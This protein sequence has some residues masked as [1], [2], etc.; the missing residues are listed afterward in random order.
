MPHFPQWALH[1]CH[2][3]AGL[4]LLCTQQ[5]HIPESWQHAW[6]TNGL[7]CRVACVSSIHL[8]VTLPSPVPTFTLSCP[9]WDAG[10]PGQALPCSQGQGAGLD[11]LLL[12]G[13]TVSFSTPPWPTFW[14]D[15]A[16]PEGQLVRQ[17]SVLIT[18]L[19]ACPGRVWGFPGWTTNSQWAWDEA[20]QGWGRSSFNFSNSSDTFEKWGKGWWNS[21]SRL[22][23]GAAATGWGKN[24]HTRP[25]W[26]DGSGP[27]DGDSRVFLQ[28]GA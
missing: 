24:H 5:S 8:S 19:E 17:C 1:S 16:N 10:C 18:V 13:H 22:C 2:R 11:L 3:T 27:T 9:G 28:R 12:Q 15:M 26:S 25:A 6:D 7:T 23:G 14:T 4:N 20:Q 21:P